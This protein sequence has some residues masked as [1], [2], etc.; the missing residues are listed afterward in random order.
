MCVP[1]WQAGIC[2]A[3]RHH[4]VPEVP[5]SKEKEAW[6][7]Q[8]GKELLVGQRE[9]GNGERPRKTASA[10]LRMEKENGSEQRQEKKK[11]CKTKEESQQVA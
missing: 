6:T 2:S 8:E 7:V 3:S 5:E 10:S 9:R 1:T 4:L 11:S